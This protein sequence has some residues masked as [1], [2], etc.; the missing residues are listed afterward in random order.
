MFCKEAADRATP[1]QSVDS[2]QGDKSGPKSGLTYSCV[3]SLSWAPL[4]F[5]QPEKRKE[6]SIINLG[7]WRDSVLIWGRAELLGVPGLIRELTLRGANLP[8][9]CEGDSKITARDDGVVGTGHV[10]TARPGMIVASGR[11]QLRAELSDGGAD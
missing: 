6:E 11:G 3:V 1:L 7:E 2:V 10:G 4:F 5:G 9:R 8:L